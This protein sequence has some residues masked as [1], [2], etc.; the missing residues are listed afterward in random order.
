MKVA[1]IQ[2]WFRVKLDNIQEYYKNH[3]FWKSI[4]HFFKRLAE[5]VGFTFYTKTLIFFELELQQTLFPPSDDQD[6]DFLKVESKDIECSEG[7]HDGWFDREQALQRL[8]EGHLLFVVKDHQ[9]IAFF[10]WIE[11]YTSKIP[12]I[13]VSSFPLPEKTACMAYIFTKPEYRGRGYVSKA[14]PL[15]L[16]YLQEQG[17]HDVFLVIAPENTISQRVNK[18]VG[19]REYQTITYRKIF[20]RKAVLLRY[21]WV[22]EYGTR[23]KKIFWCTSTSKI[24]PK[25]WNRFSK[26]HEY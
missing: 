1:Y 7:Y 9:N 4:L 22:K 2:Q 17:Y 3:G 25:L 5:Y 18:K 12:S 14:K 23:R 16:H 26:L 21:Y 11:L 20:F 15:V 8:E 19:F 10:Q 24:E 13:E 6:V